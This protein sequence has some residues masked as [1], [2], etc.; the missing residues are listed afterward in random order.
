MDAC[1]TCAYT[2]QGAIWYQG[3]ANANRAAQYTTLLSEMIRGWRQVFG[4]G[5][6]SFYTVQLANFMAPNPN[7]FDSA[8]A[9]LRNAQDIVGQEPRG[10]TATIIDIGEANDIHP[11]N[12][13]DVGE[14]LARIALKKD[15]GKSVE[16]QG[17]RF[18]S[19]TTKGDKITITFS[20][21]KGMKTTDG[22]ASRCFAIAGA[23]KQWRWATGVIKGN[24][25]ILDRLQG[26][27][28]VRYAWQD[29]P[30]VNLINSD[31]LPAM[32]FR[33]DSLP[34]ITRNNR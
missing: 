25:V 8:W 34:L 10:G 7:Q 24:T 27:T 5:D 17:P 11:R 33:T 23:D 32:P 18:K 9:E 13:R 31:G 26:E 2:I 21:A 3:E 20:H 19:I 16:W 6:F 1:A 14:R 12:K 29:N 30:P 22:Q 28:L 4:Q 15:Y